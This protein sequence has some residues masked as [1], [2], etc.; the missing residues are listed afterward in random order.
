MLRR[1]L[2][3]NVDSPEFAQGIATIDQL[4]LLTPP[5]RSSDLLYYG[6]DESNRPSAEFGQCDTVIRT[7]STL[8]EISGWAFLP[9]EDQPAAG[10]VLAYRSGNGWRGFAFADVNEERP[11][12]AKKRGDQYKRSGWRRVIDG[13]SV[14]KGN[15]Q[16][17]AWAVDAVTADVHKLPGTF[18]L[19]EE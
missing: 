16:I 2:A 5:L 11:V 9:I 18:S 12:I 14:P 10:V 19:P 8:F 13:G 3:A 6:A 15:R 7:S 17:S 4:Q 1:I